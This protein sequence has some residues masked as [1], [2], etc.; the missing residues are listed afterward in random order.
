VNCIH[1]IY[2]KPDYPWREI[3]TN[4]QGICAKFGSKNLVTGEVKYEFASVCREDKHK[5]GEDGAFF[6][7]LRTPES[8]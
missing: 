5:C 3:S 4:R 1:Y 8:K 6:I 2:Y 7:P